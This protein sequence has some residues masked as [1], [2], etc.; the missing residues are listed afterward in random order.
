MKRRTTLAEAKNMR[1][2]WLL[3][4]VL[5]M[6]SLGGSAALAL[7][8]MGP[9]A[10]RLKPGQGGGGIDYSRSE[11]D[12]ELSGGKWTRH[13]DGVF[14]DSGEALSET[15]KDFQADRAYLNL[16]YGIAKDWDAFLRVGAT[17]AEF[18][19]SMYGQGEK[20]DGSTD[21]AIGGGIRATIYEKDRLSIGGLVQVNWAK[22]D[23]KL[24]ASGWPVYNYIEA[25]IRETQIAIGATYVWTDRVSIYGGPFAHYIHG[26]F[27]EALSQAYPGGG[28]VTTKYSWDIDEGP[29]Y[30]G[31]IGAQILVAEHCFFNIEYQYTS[32]ADAYCA[33]LIFGH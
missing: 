19:D 9:P 24:K 25:D 26:G 33:S 23:G 12:I 2:T 32:D 6:V 5:L 17:T 10:A 16:G 21:F 15:I 29:T 20:F 4:L 7:D 3:G 31:Y 13:L 30:G 22:F 18:G 28:L 8:P 27:D 11:M 1:K 14:L